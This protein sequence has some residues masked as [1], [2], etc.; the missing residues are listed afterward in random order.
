MAPAEAAAELNVINSAIARDFPDTNGRTRAE[1]AHFRPGI[2]AP[3]YIILGALMTAVGL[4]L[5]V[6][7]AN[8]ANLLLARSL[9]RARE[10]SIRASLGATRWRIVRQLLVESVMLSLAAGAVAL[11]LS[12]AGIRILISYVNEIGKPAWMDFSMNMTVFLFLAS[13]CVGAGILFGV[14]PALYISK[15]G[16]GN[17]MLKQSSGRTATAGG[18]ARRLTGTLVVVEVVLTIVLVAGAVSMM[19]H[20]HAQSRASRMIDTSGLLTLNVG[21]PSQKYPGTDDRIRFFRRLDERLTA[22][23][24]AS[25]TIANARPFLGGGSA[26][27]SVDGHSPAPGESLPGVQMV[28][29]GSRYFDVIGLPLTRGRGLTSEDGSP[30]NDNVVVND[31]FVKEFLGGG[32]P[33]GRTVTLFGEDKVPRR[34]TIVGVVPVLLRDDV[35]RASVVY[36]PYLVNPAA[37]MVL[38]A[39]SDRGAAATAG[40]LREEVRALD[41]DLPL[42]NI[43]TLDNVLSEVLWVNR[44]FGG[45]FAIF[46][47]MAVLIATVGIYGVVAFTTT[48]RTQEIGIR[49]ALGA[50]RG[51]LWWTMM[52]SKVVQIGIGLSGGI[53]AAF[54]LLRLMGG[55]LVGRF[56]QDPVTLAASAGFLLAVSVLSMLPPIWRATS[57]D[58]VAALRYE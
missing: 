57:G 44:V 3:W 11:L 17:E 7:C 21:L 6:G 33:L 1:I 37:L 23:P 54:L 41:S 31:A 19:R 15:R 27:V 40:L 34:V 52:R 48:Q 4:L 28:T 12:T 56:G 46:A 8:V 35:L 42:F 20:L 16:D 13:V 5:L 45:M 30:G 43:R 29:V 10:V 49:T 32:D 36:Q 14:V 47:G 55:L 2:G 39:R 53:V 50:P 9:Q 22:I 38:L 51:H 26:K 25:I 58:P 18:W 24:G